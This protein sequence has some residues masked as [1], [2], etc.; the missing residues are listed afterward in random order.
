MFKQIFNNNSLL[1]WIYELKH[2]LEYGDHDPEGK[3]KVYYVDY[4]LLEGLIHY[5]YIAKSKWKS[6]VN[7]NLTYPFIMNYYSLNNT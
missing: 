6:R 7:P 3:A 5:I 4:V 2:K 1:N